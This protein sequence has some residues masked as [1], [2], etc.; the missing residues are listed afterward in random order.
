MLK[1]IP[2]RL[3]RWILG[4]TGSL[5]ALASIS[6][7]VLWFCF[8]F[9]FP[10]ERLNSLPAS[11]RVT[12]RTGRV[13]LQIVGKDDHWRFPVSLKDVSPWLIKA[14]IAAEDERFYSH[15]GVDLV[16][17]GRASLQNL[18]SQRVV[19]GASTL[20]M[21]LCR[22]LEPRPRS[23]TAKLIE[24]T[25]ALQAE[26]QLSKKQILEHYFNLAPYG[27]NIRGVEAASHRFFG[28]SC[29]QLSLGQAA[30]LAGLPQAPSRF[31]PDRFPDR[32]AERR[33][34][35]LSRMVE[36]GMISETEMD[37]A[38][39]EPISIT[40]PTQ[41]ELAASHAAWLALQKQPSGGRTTIDVSLQEAIED[42]V[43]THAETLPTGADIAI[44][45]I[46]IETAEILALVG[47]ANPA[48]PIDGQN[49]G[50]LAKRS[51]GSALKPFF[52]AAA[53]EARRLNSESTV[54]D[55][56][57]RRAGWKPDNFDRTFRGA[58]TVAEALRE[59]RNVPAIRVTEAIG[60]SR[61][62]GVARSCGVR[63]PPGADEVGGLAIAV[64]GVET[65]LLDLTNA[66]ATIGR[67]GVFREPKLFPETSSPQH[68]A[69]SQ[70]TSRTLTEILSTVHRTPS[71]QESTL[72][73]SRPWFMWKTGTSSGR[74]DAW[75]VGQN[76]RFAIGVWAGRFS[77]AGHRAFVGRTAAEP[78]LAKL[79][80]L[81]PLRVNVAP[82]APHEIPMT[83]PLQLQKDH[84]RGPRIVSP[85]D[86]AEFL[87]PGNRLANVPVETRDAEE[88]T[89]F[90]NQ[91]P[92]A[93][94]QARML[95]LAQG[96]YELRCVSGDGQTDAVHFTVR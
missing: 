29:R 71:G 74:R 89:W 32:A 31:R 88:A 7:A 30:L 90:L 10:G 84:S 56:P 94:A 14:T 35:V 15:G 24:S 23:L 36:A 20:T 55:S 64:G 27:G 73:E 9:P 21:Q 63:V 28:R 34:Y 46:E 86:G 41:H 77:G 76:G 25:R 19:S 44:V 1:R 53:F 33:R 16:A 12:D 59:S 78:L 85:S 66:Y 68:R 70:L 83:R 69:L 49:N 26:R 18:E 52:Y 75:A 13:L 92:V 11:P 8:P 67:E 47:S 91:K 54:S 79:F 39:A 2:K 17:I 50:V 72:P 3:R 57:I 48:D 6:F 42:E 40:T 96:R 37:R 51:P 87:S 61:C 45:V 43:T 65:T 82:P 80:S 5:L 93:A 81:Q 60:V 38:L 62:L 22:M 4:V 95:K 58:I